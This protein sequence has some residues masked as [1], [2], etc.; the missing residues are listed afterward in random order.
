MGPVDLHV[1]TLRWARANGCP[2]YAITRDQAAE[3]LGYTDDFGQPPRPGFFS[4]SQTYHL[5]PGSTSMHQKNLVRR[6]LLNTFSMGTS[7]RLHQAM[8]IRGSM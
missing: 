1:E 4:S 8:V 3:E 5:K 7:L 6:L 2:W